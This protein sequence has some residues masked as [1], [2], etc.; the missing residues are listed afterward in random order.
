MG[1]LEN[2]GFFKR[3]ILKEAIPLV[4]IVGMYVFGTAIAYD[5]P[6]L[7]TLILGIGAQQAGWLAHDYIHGRGEWCDAMRWFGAVFNG[8]SAEWWSQKHSLHHSFTNEEAHDHDIMMEP[9]YYMRPPAESGRP[10][11]WTR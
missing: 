8:H 11:S 7:A 5:H 4:Q 10:D 3:N 2:E 6:I 9:F 1:Q